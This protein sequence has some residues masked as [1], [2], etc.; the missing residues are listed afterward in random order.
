M[1][2]KNKIKRINY[3]LLLNYFL[4]SCTAGPR[5][6]NVP[7]AYSENNSVSYEQ[8]M[9]ICAPIAELRAIEARQRV[10]QQQ[11][12]KVS[13]IEEYECDTNYSYYTSS[14]RTSCKPKAVGGTFQTGFING[15]IDS[16]A[17]SSAYNETKKIVLQSCL[18]EKGWGYRTICVENCSA[19]N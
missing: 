18:A 1:I 7:Y 19:G 17:R 11:S 4:A 14:S 9:S 10:E 12:A 6:K 5:Y 3:L 2:M 15:Y 13:Q 8:A 16:E